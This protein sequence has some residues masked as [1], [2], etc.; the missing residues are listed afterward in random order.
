MNLQWRRYWLQL[1]D[2]RQGSPLIYIV[3][4][5]IGFSVLIG[6]IVAGLGTLALVVM[7]LASLA[8]WIYIRWGQRAF[9]Q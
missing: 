5:A 3:A 7:F 1:C 2:Q 8:I 4:L 9:M 6:M